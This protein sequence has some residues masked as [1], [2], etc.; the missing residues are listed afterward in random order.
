MMSTFLISPERLVT[1]PR[2]PT[3]LATSQG[4]DA[5]LSL[6]SEPH[7]VSHV[8]VARPAFCGDFGGRILV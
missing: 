1:W 6:G 4:Q 2:P 3:G 7:S 5:G 8:A